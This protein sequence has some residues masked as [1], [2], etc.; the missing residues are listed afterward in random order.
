MGASA[1]ALPVNHA[2]GGAK[3]TG[4]RSREEKAALNSYEDGV[5]RINESVFKLKLT[6]FDIYV[7][8]KSL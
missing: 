3:V 8:I 5:N 7:N 2:G 4:G 6:F 1:P